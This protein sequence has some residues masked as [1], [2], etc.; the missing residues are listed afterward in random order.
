MGAVA[1]AV[2]ALVERQ[3]A[4]GGFPLRPGCAVRPDAT[5]WAAIALFRFGAGSDVARRACEALAGMQQEDGRVPIS[6]EAPEAAW[7]TALALS[8]WQLEGGYAEQR[9][10]A[11]GFLLEHAGRSWPRDPTSPFGHDTSI[12]GWSWTLK[13]HSWVIPTAQAVMALD[14]EGYSRH[15]RVREGVRMLLDRQ[16]AG[17]GWNYGNTTIFGRPLRPQLEPTGAALAA[18]EGHVRRQDV[19]ESLA[20]ARAELDRVRTPLSTGWGL[21]GCAAWGEAPADA[22]GRIAQTLERQD[23]AGPYDAVALAVL[24]TAAAAIGGSG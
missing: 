5:A 19:A 14:G 4:G 12:R 18:L 13:A 3:A 1:E 15:E 22:A 2:E 23:T 24:V 6:P 9:S 17:G 21:L 8:A 20:Y 10:K 11:A 7:P 16:L